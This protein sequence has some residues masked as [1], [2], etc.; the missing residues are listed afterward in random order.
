MLR[1]KWHDALLAR[2]ISTHAQLLLTDWFGTT[3]ADT[4]C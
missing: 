1:G 2:E 4:C 3:F